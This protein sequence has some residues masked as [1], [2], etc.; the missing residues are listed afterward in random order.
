M[1]TGEGADEIFAG[2]SYFSTFE[3]S[4]E[5]HECCAF[6]VDDLH[7]SQL[8]RVD[9]CS[10]AHG[11]EARVPFLDT[12]FV[13]FAMSLNPD[14]KQCTSYADTKK[15]LRAAFSDTQIPEEILWRAKLPAQDGYGQ[16]WKKGLV[17]YCS[18]MAKTLEPVAGVTHPVALYLYHQLA[19]VLGAAGM[20]ALTR[21]KLQDIDGERFPNLRRAW[22][23]DKEAPSDKDEP[24]QKTDVAP[25]VESRPEDRKRFY[26][27]EWS[28]AYTVPPA[29][30]NDVKVVMV[31][32]SCRPSPASTDVAMELRDADSI[33]FT[34]SAGEGSSSELPAVDAA[35]CLLQG[36]AA[37]E[38]PPPVWICTTDTQPTAGMSSSLHAGLWGLTRACRRELPAL[39]SWCV[40]LREGAQ[41][42]RSAAA[43]VYSQALRLA[44]GRVYG[45]RQS[46][47][48]EPEAAFVSDALILP[49]LVA[50]AVTPQA[51]AVAVQLASLS[52]LL[53]SHTDVEQSKLDMPRMIEA[54]AMLENMC[55]QY[56]REAMKTLT[57]DEVPI[58]HHKLLFA[59]CGKQPLPD[60]DKWPTD[61]K[62]SDVDKD[63]WAEL[64][65]AAQCGPALADALSFKVNYMDL[66]FPGGSLHM[67]AP[68]YEHD[69]VTMFYN[70]CIEAGIRCLLKLMP[71]E[72][73][74][75]MLE[76]GAGVGATSQSTLPVVAGRCDR[77]Y[78][79][80][81]SDAFL[82]KAR[83]R[84][85]K[86]DFIDYM[87]CNIDADPCLQGFAPH[88]CDVIV[89]TNVLHATPFIRNTLRNCSTLLKHGGY[90]IA[91]EEVAIFDR[92]FS[93]TT[94]LHNT[95]FALTDGWWLFGESGDGER[96]GQDSPLLSW[97][98]W[99]AMLSDCGFQSSYCMQ[100][101][102]FLLDQAVIV[103]RMTP[104]HVPTEGKGLEEGA[105]FFSGGLGGLALLQARLM[106]EG[107]ACHLVLSS[108][109]D[110]VVD[111]SDADWK[112]LANVDSC[113][114]RRVVCDS[115]D[116]GTVRKVMRT[117]IGDGV[118]VT[119]IFHAAHQLAD[120]LLASQLADHFRSAYAPKVHGASALHA[121]TGCAPLRFFNMYSS[122]AALF[123][124]A[125]Q[126]PH[127]AASQW[128]NSMADC[129]RRM[130]A[131]GL[132]IL[133]GVVNGF[134]DS[135]HVKDAE[136]SGLGAISRAMALST[137]AATLL[138]AYRSFACMPVNWSQLLA[139]ST[140]AQG[141]MVAYYHLRSRPAAVQVAAGGVSAWSKKA[142][143]AS[144]VWLDH[145]Q[146]L[147]DRIIGGTVD[148]DT[149]LMDAGVDSL[150][151]VEIRS[152]LQDR[153]GG[154][155][156]VPHTL[157]FEYPIARQVVSF[158]ASH[159]QTEALVEENV[160]DGTAH[161]HEPHRLCGKS[162]LLP[163]GLT[164]SEA[165]SMSPCTNDLVQEVPYARWDITSAMSFKSEEVSQRVRHGGFVHMTEPFDN[166][167][168]SVSPAEA[169][170][171]DP[172][173][174]LLLEWGYL[175][176][177][178]AKLNSDPADSG[179]G[180][181][182]A[183]IA[184]E[185]GDLLAASPDAESVF[186]FASQGG[187]I[188]VASGR[189][190]YSLGLQ[191]PCAT[192]NTACSSSLVA[193][194]ATA[195]ALT[196]GECTLGLSAAVNLMLTPAC[197]VSLAIGGFTSPR[198]RCFT[199][200][201]R[202]EGYV[203]CE[204]C[205]G[206]TLR[207]SSKQ[208]GPE[209]CANAVKQ[210][211]RSA[212]LTAPNGLAQQTLLCAILAFSSTTPEEFSCL[213]AHGTG[214]ALGDPIEVRSFVEV[215]LPKLS[216]RT[217]RLAVSSSK[218]NVGHGES[219]AGF[220]G[221]LRVVLQLDF[222]LAAPNVH[223]RQVNEHLLHSV[224]GPK[225]GLA[226]QFISLPRCSED[227]TSAQA[228]S[229][230]SSF[231]YSGTIAHVMLRT[232]D[233]GNMNGPELPM[234][235]AR[236]AFPWH[237]PVHPFVQHLLSLPGGALFR[238]PAAGALYTAVAGHV[239][240][241]RC[242]FPGSGYFVMAHAAAPQDVSAQQGVYIMQ[243][244]LVET[245]RLVIDC[246][247]TRGR[248]E[249]RSGTP[250][251]DASLEDVTEHCAGAYVSTAVV[252]W[253][254]VDHLSVRGIKGAHASETRALYNRFDVLGLQYG[255]T[256]RVLARAW[257]GDHGGSASAVLR[258]RMAREGMEVHP[259]DID[260][261]QGISLALEKMP[262]VFSVGSALLQG[263]TGE[264]W[265]RRRF[266]LHNHSTITECCL[267]SDRFVLLS[268]GRGLV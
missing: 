180:V 93:T 250:Q 40:D 67:V 223:L 3:K 235:F 142:P 167:H 88:Q 247:V 181:F 96:V 163:G 102:R 218:A 239:V 199:F 152:L 156:H 28:R 82:H 108:R 204:A 242:I 118:V 44:T 126:A 161:T 94:R 59:W 61:I 244:L 225:C 176:L 98:Q 127:L 114:V 186:A 130:A 85:A 215:I 113:D 153:A 25:P 15:I 191:G 262:M 183:I 55:L 208:L 137:L 265:V 210:D 237:E 213:E 187:A 175:S 157:V 158:L 144:A 75:T 56:L 18:E 241:G 140:E 233:E 198:G 89:A 37:L 31:G 100:G 124:S 264:L 74:V 17:K 224:R 117:P 4:V 70:S 81:V 120:A 109:S 178:A 217:D 86:Y 246:E 26:E 129:R 54:Y 169:A 193:L 68:T 92:A 123:G 248:F 84:F 122:V 214:T 195:S 168:F 197:T 6:L 36:Q 73:C 105:H 261:A 160:G 69:V 206:V 60:T 64:Q 257:S 125:G 230:V 7:L 240:Q 45:L 155:V 222:A 116:Q 226:A 179:A 80:D 185:F 166:K 201:Q 174:R 24:V 66:L 23:K 83:V 196:L 205:G 47:S 46:P 194:H 162:S 32:H 52:E 91:N 22:A 150:N 188:A 1:F 101:A 141:F 267:C 106:V 182:V 220:V 51:T 221:L 119:G 110:R 134:E 171:M 143:S 173:Q 11:I 252:G 132:T 131:P 245:P 165:S 90:L 10:M 253:Q 189:I 146:G 38:K 71:P 258:P 21:T 251:A 13:G 29:S 107:G 219:A 16:Q 190:S 12:D 76:V 53:A 234:V 42:R 133:W 19:P 203:R 149:P 147:L 78:F 249:V 170:A 211:G 104:A 138:P 39:P 202:G 209:L 216:T 139:G 43:L 48:V 151:S 227:D 77:Y 229:G 33:V 2:Y 136:M 14:E 236:R 50:P 27:I 30:A 41:S 57:A 256:Y 135:P 154:A 97:R 148:V 49:R 99:Q 172:Q 9:R 266:S 121:A 232:T 192:I 238:S 72:K 228:I 231:G 63:L 58:W 115:S 87:L 112:W 207:S 254:R 184:T 34:A 103:G 263:V 35:L 159:S 111:G 128:A 268:L 65:L 255:P 260:D 5:V 20:C 62:P 145:F 243:P 164:S 259:A 212:S 177:H 79:T 200:D 8:L 95:T